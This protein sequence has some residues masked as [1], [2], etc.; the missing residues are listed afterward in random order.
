MTY[1]HSK[2][3]CGLPAKCLLPR[4]QAEGLAYGAAKSHRQAHYFGRV[5]D[6]ADFI[7][8]MPGSASEMWLKSGRRAVKVAKP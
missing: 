2:R 8:K 3:L 4:A 1:R 5:P 7:E 6:T